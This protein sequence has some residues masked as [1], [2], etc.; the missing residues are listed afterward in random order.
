MD[1]NSFNDTLL[2]V[3]TSDSTIVPLI[4]TQQSTEG[5]K[6]SSIAN[7]ISEGVKPQI[8]KIEAVY[9]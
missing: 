5:I 2:I 4:F 9:R 3:A 6:L 7:G 1:L 8:V